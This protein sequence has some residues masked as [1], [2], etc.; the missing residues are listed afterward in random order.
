MLCAHFLLP[1]ST[2]IVYLTNN[3][4]VYPT[5]GAI[6]IKYVAQIDNRGVRRSQGKKLMKTFVGLDI[7]EI[8]PYKECD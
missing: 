2:Q 5:H 7:I 4:N 8:F 3:T 6:F 1:Q